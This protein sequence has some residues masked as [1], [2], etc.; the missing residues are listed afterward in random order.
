M[1]A[2]PNLPH[3]NRFQHWRELYLAALF[4][5]DKMRLPARVA[6]AEKAMLLRIRDLFHSSGMKSDE[7][8]AVDKGLYA[9]RALRQCFGLNPRNHDEHADDDS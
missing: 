4:E 5:T 3:S 2:R 1:T 8:K 6:E 9:M 7:A